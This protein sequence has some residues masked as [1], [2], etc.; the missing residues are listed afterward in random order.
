MLTRKPITSYPPV[1]PCRGPLP[2]S[3]RHRRVPRHGRPRLTGGGSGWP[4]LMRKWRSYGQP[5]PRSQEGGIVPVTHWLHWRR[6]LRA[7]QPMKARVAFVKCFFVQC[8]ATNV[9]VKDN[10][11]THVR[12][13]S[14]FSQGQGN[15][16]PKGIAGLPFEYFPSCVL[17]ILWF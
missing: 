1:F 12:S 17:V 13:H 10:N 14:D 2:L 16:R 11:K 8:C 4:L 15:G 3:P 6:E 5:R 9:C 7:L